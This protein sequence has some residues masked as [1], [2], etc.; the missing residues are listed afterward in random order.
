MT[1]ETYTERDINHHGANVGDLAYAGT[2]QPTSTLTTFG[3]I[4]PWYSKQQLVRTNV[5]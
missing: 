2:S 1:H 4:V 3:I 5:W